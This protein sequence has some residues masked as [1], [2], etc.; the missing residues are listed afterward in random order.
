[1]LCQTTSAFSTSCYSLVL[2]SLRRSQQGPS[3]SE[4]TSTAKS[5]L[6]SCSMF[7]FSQ[8]SHRGYGEKV[9]SQRLGTKILVDLV[10]TSSEVHVDS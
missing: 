10:S 3:P 6:K 2:N 7:S 8:S 5:L 1:M 4:H 9:G